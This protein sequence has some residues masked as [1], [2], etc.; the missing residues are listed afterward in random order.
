[1][2]KRI[3]T[4]IRNLKKPIRIKNYVGFPPIFTAGED[5]RKKL[6]QPQILIIEEKPSGVFLYRYAINGDFSGDTWH[7][8]F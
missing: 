8:N 3:F 4:I 2:N 7:K 6:P 5:Q 1:M